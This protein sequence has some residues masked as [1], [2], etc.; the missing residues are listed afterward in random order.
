MLICINFNLRV[1]KTNIFAAFC[2]KR[3]L[4]FHMIKEKR[5]GINQ[6]QHKVFL[7]FYKSLTFTQKIDF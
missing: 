4:K 3:A 2:K 7:W 5:T 1:L 6:Q